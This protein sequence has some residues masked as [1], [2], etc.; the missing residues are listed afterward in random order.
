MD[1]L[2]KAH[3]FLKWAGGKRKLMPQIDA[4]LPAALKNGRLQRYI[5]PFVGSGALFFYIAQTYPLKEYFINDVNSELIMAYKTIQS[6]VE[7]LIDCLTAIESS[8]LP[9]DETARKAFYY[10]TRAQFNQHGAE[11][12]LASFQPQWVTRTAQLIFLNRTCYNGLFRVNSKGGFNVPFGRYKNPTICHADNLRVVARVLQGVWIENGRYETFSQHVNDQTFVYFD[13][14]YRPLSQ[15]A[16]FT[17]YTNNTFGDVEQLKL[18]DFYHQLNSVG[19]KLML[20]NSDPQNIDP[21]DTFFEGAYANFRIE[22]IQA[23]RRINSRAN[24]RGIV[25]ELLIMNY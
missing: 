17:A 5:E 13:P 19:A 24:K 25:N 6:E 23:S 16:N 21:A 3:P 4:Y 12:D 15:T 18:A 22:R 11:L 14:P 20:S 8:Y 9:L 7:S 2:Q 10:K 1:N